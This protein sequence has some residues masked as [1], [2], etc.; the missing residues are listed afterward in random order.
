MAGKQHTEFLE[1]SSI[2]YTKYVHSLGYTLQ[3]KFH[4]CLPFLGIALPLSQFPHS[5]VSDL[6][7]SRTSPHVS[8][9]R[10]GRSIVGI[11]KSLSVLILCSVTKLIFFRWLQK[12]GFF[13]S[14]SDLDVSKIVLFYFQQGLETRT[15]CLA[16]KCEKCDG[17]ISPVTE[18]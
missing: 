3:R 1:N 11:Y 17:E 10:I 16:M 8:C 7:I 4:L 6:Y 5:C 12:N 13:Y 18:N 2:I 9:S 14:L 15:S